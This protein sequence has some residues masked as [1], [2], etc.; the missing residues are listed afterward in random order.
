MTI[1]EA[2]KQG[3]SQDFKNA[4]PK[5]QFQNFCPSRFSNLFTSNPGNLHFSYVQ[6]Y[7]LLGKIFV[8]YPQKVKIENSLKKILPVQ[9]G[10]FQ[11]TTCPKDRQ[12]GS[13]LSACSKGIHIGLHE[14]DELQKQ[15]AGHP[16]ISLS[17]PMRG[18]FVYCHQLAQLL[19]EAI[20]FNCTQ[21]L[22]PIC[23]HHGL[24]QQ[25]V[26]LDTLTLKKHPSGH[27]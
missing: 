26:F 22:D 25:G 6:T 24:S 27:P 4:C 2:L 8:Y 14:S 15:D 9:K 11:E 17:D 10:G 3:L 16:F 21:V 18:E 13:W 1:K 20:Y 19:A 7:D 5:Q 23:P 12:D